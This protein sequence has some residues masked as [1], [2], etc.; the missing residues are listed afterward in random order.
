MSTVRNIL[1]SC[2]VF[3]LSICAA[4][5][6][7]WP[8]FWLSDKIMFSD[9]FLSAIAMG[10]WISKGE[11]LAA[12]LAG[13]LVAGTVVDQ[14]PF[15]WALVVAA[16]DLLNGLFSMRGKWS[17]P[18]WDRVWQSVYV[19]FPAAACVVAALLTTHLRRS[20]TDIQPT[21]E[22]TVS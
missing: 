6:L 8:F 12:I 5:L 3:Y 22:R 11:T 18:P 4:P 19:L 9:N 14:K 16:F 20:K 21:E 17:L 15:R 13:A 7:A 1:I 10:I 2:G